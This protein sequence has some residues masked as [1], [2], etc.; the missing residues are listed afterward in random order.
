MS[1]KLLHWLHSS[2]LSRAVGGDGEVGKRISGCLP[3]ALARVRACVRERERER[4]AAPMKLSATASSGMTACPSK[5]IEGDSCGAP[6]ENPLTT[7]TPPPPAVPSSPFSAY[8]GKN[9]IGFCTLEN[10]EEA[11][12]GSRC[13][14]GQRAGGCSDVVRLNTPPITQEQARAM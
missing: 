13:A 1:Q 5:E 10:S 7:P 11:S 14:A 6:D 12:E 4:T 2:T 9:T 8:L 3:R